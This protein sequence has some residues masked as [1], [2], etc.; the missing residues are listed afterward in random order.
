MLTL[1]ADWRDLSADYL[2]THLL[3]QA[4]VAGMYHGVASLM[5]RAC[6]EQLVESRGWNKR[7]DPITVRSQRYGF[8]IG[9]GL[10]HILPQIDDA[11]MES[12]PKLARMG[13]VTT[14]LVPPWSS[15]VA[16]ECLA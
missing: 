3:H 5:T 16:R 12:I 14:V 15:R 10:F 9:G 8:R 13:L 1:P 11:A 4:C 7:P 2:A 6:L